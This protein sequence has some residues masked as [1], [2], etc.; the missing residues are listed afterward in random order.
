MR[1]LAANLTLGCIAAVICASCV[2]GSLGTRVTVPLDDEPADLAAKRF[3]PGDTTSNVYL[4][5]CSEA[6]IGVRVEVALNDDWHVLAA[7]TYF[8]F[9]VE[10]GEHSVAVKTTLEDEEPIRFDAIAGRNY[11]FKVVAS[12]SFPAGRPIHRIER[13]D[14]EQKGQKMIHRWCNRAR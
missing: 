3:Q 13:I 4:A 8:L 5:R 11:Y 7:R 1:S 14:D 10:S 2:T 6:A 9:V 12:K